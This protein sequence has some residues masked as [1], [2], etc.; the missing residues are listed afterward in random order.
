MFDPSQHSGL[1]VAPV[2]FLAC[3]VALAF[4]VR[5][6]L[7]RFPALVSDCLRMHHHLPYM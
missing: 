1:F 6:C 3:V 4:T 7:R 5:V 2:A